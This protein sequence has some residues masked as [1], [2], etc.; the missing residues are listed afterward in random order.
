MLITNVS[1]QALVVDYL[2]G[3]QCTTSE[4]RELTDSPFNLEQL[5]YA[6]LSLAPGESVLIPTRIVFPASPS[7]KSVFS[8]P[9]AADQIFKRL[10]TNGFNVDRSRYGSPTFKDYTYGPE[11]SVSGLSLNGKRIDWSRRQAN[12]M[13]LVVSFEAGSCPY[14]LAWDSKNR[15]WINHG[16]VLHKAPSKD[17][18]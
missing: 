13:D 12:F 14:L 9:R 15:D 7:L 8:S 4:L 17:R 2:Q 10:G 18:D 1:G 11:L 3:R 16:K 6:A 5:P